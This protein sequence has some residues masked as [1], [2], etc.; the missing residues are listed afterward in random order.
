MAKFKRSQ[1]FGR[2]LNNATP[3]QTHQKKQIISITYF[4]AKAYIVLWFK[5]SSFPSFLVDYLKTPKFSL[6]LQL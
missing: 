5:V 2:S 4:M 6:K 3:T 1:D